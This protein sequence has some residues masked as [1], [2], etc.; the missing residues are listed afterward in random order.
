MENMEVKKSPG[1]KPKNEADKVKLATVYLTGKEQ[2][3]IKE[4]YG[5]ITTAIRKVIVPK[6]KIS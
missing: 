5:N 3:A 1:R 2:D 6:L 4:K